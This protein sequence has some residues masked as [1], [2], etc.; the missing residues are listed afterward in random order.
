[1]LTALVPRSVQAGVLSTTGLSILRESGFQIASIPNLHAKVCLIDSDWGLVGS[2]NLTG[3]GLDGEEG[4]NVELGVVLNSVQ[5]RVA[6]DLVVGW[7]EEKADPVG[8]A[9]IEIF[10][11]LPRF[12]RPKGQPPPVGSPLQ[13]IGSEGLK[14]ILSED[15]VAAERHHWIKSNY[16]RPE[17]EQWWHRNWISDWRQGPY[18][19]GDLVVL[20]LSARDGG[21]ACCPAV[22]EVTAPSEHNPEW[23]IS[24]RDAEAAE[25]WPYVTRTRLVGEV[26]IAAGAKL[27]VVGKNGQS[28]QGG[29]CGI[30]RDEFERLVR[31]M[32]TSHSQPI[33]SPSSSRP[34]SS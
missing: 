12:P 3:S 23:V 28:V 21:P 1:M 30:D 14:R 10:A 33:P 5:R 6:S 17:D 19:V 32:L 22:V 7:W 13:L 8:A 31:A 27:A 15:G 29:Y 25:R 9:E 20:Y 2:G 24:H 4:G 34:Y 11:A 18:E 26:P 16:H